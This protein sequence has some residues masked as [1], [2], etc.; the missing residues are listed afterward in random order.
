MT[1]QIDSSLNK[2]HESNRICLNNE[3]K[4]AIKKEICEEKDFPATENMNPVE[5]MEL[6]KPEEFFVE[7]D[8]MNS[9]N[10]TNLSSRPQNAMTAVLREDVASDS[11]KKTILHNEPEMPQN[12]MTAVLRED[13]CF[14]FC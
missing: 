14:K 11:V 9:V 3:I 7:E 8:S 10:K 6:D 5:P 12:A 13:V 4:Q 2:G 1:G